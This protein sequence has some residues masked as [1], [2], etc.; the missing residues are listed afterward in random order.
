MKKEFEEWQKN[1]KPSNN[2]KTNTKE[3]FEKIMT[4]AK[5]NGFIRPR[6]LKVINSITGR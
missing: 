3:V 6:D 5:K 1:I 2:K 4:Q